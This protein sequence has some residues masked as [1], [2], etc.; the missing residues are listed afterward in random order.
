MSGVVITNETRQQKE[1]LRKLQREW[2]EYEVAR[3]AQGNLI[4]SR[5]LR[6]IK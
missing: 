5:F 2:E 6:V 3:K 4:N 1:N